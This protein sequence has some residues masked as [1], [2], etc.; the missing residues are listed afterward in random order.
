[1]LCKKNDDIGFKY[2]NKT[3]QPWTSLS[4]YLK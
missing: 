4:I 2:L 3:Q 1:M